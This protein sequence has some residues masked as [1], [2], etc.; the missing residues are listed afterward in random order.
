MSKP[1]YDPRRTKVHLIVDGHHALK[2][3]LSSIQNARQS[4][5]IKM[6]MWREDEMGLRV[7]KALERKIQQSPSIHIIIEKDIFGSRV[8][9][10]QRVTSL[11]KMRGDIF[12][13]VYGEQ[14]LNN[15][16]RNVTFIRIGSKSVLFFKILK[17]NDHSKVFVFD[18]NTPRAC[19]LIG[20]MNM[21]NE[22]LTAPNHK[23]PKKGGWHDYMLLIRGAV[24]THLLRPVS[25][26]NKLWLA[27]TVGKSVEILLNI[28][29][30]RKMKRYIIRELKE[31]KKSVI[32]EHGYLTDDTIIRH[33]RRISRKGVKVIV[34]L[35]DR[36]DGVFHANMQSV[37]NLLRPSLIRGHKASRVQVY[38]YRGMIHAK[39][40]IID[41]ETSIIGSANLTPNS[42]D[43]LNETNAVIRKRK[44]ITEALLNQITAD[45]KVSHLVDIH[46]IPPFNRLRAWFEKIFI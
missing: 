13:S 27:N 26:K 16:R 6:F 31:A 44:G 21:G 40:I 41:E 1:I 30:R 28:K 12:Y 25:R 24:A 45:L 33:L 39:V 3:I 9:N 20:G 23:D 15:Y 35:P 37:H 2:I 46:S 8:Y 32:V 14:F 36:S 22:Y 18:A 38:L 19:A 5:H 34:I 7:L 17:E 29:G 11:G 43:Y 4:I 10:W 42:F